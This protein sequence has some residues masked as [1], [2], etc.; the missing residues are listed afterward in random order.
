MSFMSEY[1]VNDGVKKSV[2]EMYRKYLR[3]E[4]IEDLYRQ[5]V[6]ISYSLGEELSERLHMLPDREGYNVDPVIYPPCKF[7]SLNVIGSPVYQFIYQ[8]M[9]PL[10]IQDKKYENKIREYYLRSTM[11]ALE[12][13][14]LEKFDHAFIYLCHFYGDLKV[15]DLDNRN[16]RHLINAI[17]NTGIIEDDCWQRIET[18]ESGFLDLPKSNHVE[19]FITSRENMIN[20]V[21]YVRKEVRKRGQN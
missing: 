1:D 18:M 4:T 7:Q 3:I 13:Q 6:M 8:G 19:V 16:R 14:R 12:G 17:R 5:T 15:R 10:Y 2:D 11:E 20:L 21:E 9:L